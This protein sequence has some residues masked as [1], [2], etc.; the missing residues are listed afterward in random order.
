MN[1]I[2]QTWK[3]QIYIRIRIPTYAY[4]RIYVRTRIRT[5]SKSVNNNRGPHGC[6]TP[7]STDKLATQTHT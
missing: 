3:Q 7:Q 2:E 6:E 1:E 4:E 5:Y